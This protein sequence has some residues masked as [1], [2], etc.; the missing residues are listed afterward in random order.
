MTNT[1][2]HPDGPNQTADVR[3]TPRMRPWKAR[4]PW[5]LL[6]LT[7][8]ISGVWVQRL[9]S[10]VQRSRTAAAAL[11]WEEI[12]DLSFSISAVQDADQYD[13]NSHLMNAQQQGDAMRSATRMYEQ[14]MKTAPDQ[15]G[16]FAK[17][18]RLFSLTADTINHTE[19][20]PD[21][22]GAMNALKADMRLVLSVFPEDL[23]IRGDATEL[24]QAMTTWCAQ[25]QIK[26]LLVAQNRLWED[27][28]PC[29]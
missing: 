23:L 20:L 12:N 26:P 1:P 15:A 2:G 6:V 3:R 17:L 29:R 5:L 4:L 13:G 8:V 28:G 16:R 18:F 24:D 10:D 19:N 25:A 9:R 22:Q 11:L 14:A 27:V 21:E 7:I